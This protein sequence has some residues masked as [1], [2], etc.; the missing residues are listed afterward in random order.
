L[1][2]KPVATIFSSLTSKP[3]TMVSPDLALKSVV[4]RVSRF[5]LQNWQLRFS[6]LGIKITATIS[7]FWPQNQ[8]GFDLSVASQNRQRRSGHASRSSGLLCVKVSLARVSQFASKL[9]EARRRVVHVA[10][11]WRSCEDQVENGWVDTTDCIGPYYAYFAVFYV[12]Y[13]MAILIF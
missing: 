5:W 4:A 12:L 1:T 9:V 8:V 2:S 6:D 10:L 3:V 7:W 11:L 13:I